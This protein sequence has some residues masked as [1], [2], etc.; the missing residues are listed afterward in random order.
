M[1]SISGSFR[2]HRSAIMPA[3]SP[4]TSRKNRVTV[5]SAPASAA[6]TVKLFWMSIRMNVMMAKSNP[7]RVQ[8]RKVAR[9]ARH[10]WPSTC[11]YHGVSG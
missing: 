2:P 11:R 5:P 10:C 1:D 8:P 7:P 4:P 6:S 3:P 9:N